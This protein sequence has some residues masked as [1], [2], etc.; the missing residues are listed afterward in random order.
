MMG[1][2]QA[3][4]YGWSFFNLAIGETIRWLKPP[5]GR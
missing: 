4:D 2:A 3:W 5:E 1:H